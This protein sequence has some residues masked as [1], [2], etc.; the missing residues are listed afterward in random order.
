M[1]TRRRFYVYPRLQYS[2]A[3]VSTG[4]IQSTLPAPFLYRLDLQA[5]FRF[6]HCCCLREHPAHVSP[7]SRV[8]KQRLNATNGR[9][10]NILVP[11]LSLS[12]VDD[13]LGS[14]GIDCPLDLAWAHSSA[15]GD[16]L[17]ANV[18]G[19][20]SGAIQRQ[21]DGGLELGLGALDL[22]L[23][24]GLGKAGPLAQSKVHKVVDTGKLVSN[25]VDTPETT[26]R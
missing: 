5:L 2:S 25:E 14:D 8:V 24:D 15:S 9:N 4:I 3:G 18:L 6:P 1:T 17:S 22:G 12:E 16:D 7:E 19:K 10:G 20:G 21:Q 11:D 26:I 23:G 13:V